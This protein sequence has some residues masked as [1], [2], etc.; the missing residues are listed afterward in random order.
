[1]SAP[2]I[3]LS[4]ARIYQFKSIT[5]EWHNYLGPTFIRRKDWEP[6]N[7]ER[8]TNRDYALLSKW[9]DLNKDEREHY[10]IFQTA[11]EMT[12]DMARGKPNDYTTG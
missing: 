7:Q 10:R 11:W 9:E 2:Q 6:K 12:R 8:I 5:F 4:Q 1:M 3:K